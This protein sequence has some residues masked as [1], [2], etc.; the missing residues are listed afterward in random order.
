MRFLIQFARALDTRLELDHRTCG[1]KTPLTKG[2]TCLSPRQRESVPSFPLPATPCP[3]CRLTAQASYSNIRRSPSRPPPMPGRRETP[4]SA[5]PRSNQRH[6][7]AGWSP[8]PRRDNQCRRSYRLT[9]WPRPEAGRR[10]RRLRPSEGRGGRR[11]RPQ[12]PSKPP[13][14]AAC[15]PHRAVQTPPAYY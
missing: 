7:C 1:R 15:G 13:R 11:P 5:P 14:A 10:G 9:P 8:P 3:V 6:P 2:A 4:C 12:P